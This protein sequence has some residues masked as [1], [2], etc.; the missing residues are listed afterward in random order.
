MVPLDFTIPDQADVDAVPDLILEFPLLAELLREELVSLMALEEATVE[1][2]SELIRSAPPGESLY[3]AARQ[4]FDDARHLETLCRRLDATLAASQTDAPTRESVGTPALH[5]Y[6]DDCLVSARRGTH[7]E[8][9]TRLN[10]AF[11]SMAAT[12]YRLAARYWRWLDPRLCDCLQEM[13][14]DEAVH[15][16]RAIQLVRGRNAETPLLELAGDVT[17]SLPGAFRTH[18]ASFVSRFGTAM[19]RHREPFM[20]AEFVH[21]RQLLRVPED[22]QIAFI[23]A[24]CMEALIGAL[25]QAGLKP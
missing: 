14:E 1:V 18:I 6:F 13:A 9:L 11:K 10:V 7:L 3:F 2:A 20:D 12:F 17:S 24:R 25:A 16:R 22:E 5:A 4:T 15:V 19:R 8:T 23:H 21:G